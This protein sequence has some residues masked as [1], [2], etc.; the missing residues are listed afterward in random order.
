MLNKTDMFMASLGLPEVYKVG[1][2]VRDELLGR[3]SKDADYVVRKATI[4]EIRDAVVAAG[5]K[6]TKLKLRTGKEVGVRA[7]VKGLGLIEIVLPRIERSTGPGRHDFEITT[8][9]NV[10]LVEDAIRRDFTINA[11]YKDISTDELVDPLSAGLNDLAAQIIRTTHHDSFRDDPLRILR[12]LRFVSTLYFDLST[13]TYDQMILHAKSV[14]GLTQKGV[15]STA[16]D[17]L[18]RLLMG[19]NPG[20][21]LRIAAKTGVLAVLLPELKPMIGYKQR[22][23]YHKKTTDIHTFDAIQAAANMR[24]HAPLRV[25]L[26]LLF[27]DCGKPLMAWR[28][29]DG[30]DHYYAL[31]AKT[32]LDLGLDGVAVFPHETWSA[33][34]A[35]KALKRLNTPRKLLN[36]VVKLIEWHMLPLDSKRK[37]IKVRTWRAELGDDLLYDLIVH[38][39]ADVLGKG[40]PKTEQIGALTEIAAEQAAAIS[41]KVPCSP[42]ELAVS[43][44]DLL[45][46]GLKGAEIGLIQRQLLH[47]VLAQPKL[48]E[49]EWL[50]GRASKLASKAHKRKGTIS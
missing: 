21:A 17:E 32:I 24:Q 48:N 4:Q 19:N 31:D 36:D 27:H 2:S 1:G 42:R 3:K 41:E 45:S 26:A 46:L 7:A 50:L 30:Y 43:G 47:E 29:P 25:R 38:R 39:L 33:W 35:T 20:I 6:P 23:K 14:T 22:S 28:G 37:P 34:E 16:L 44:H 18:C 8:N 9:P 5:A 49:K 13:D 15:S 11:L 40:E 12:A 10:S